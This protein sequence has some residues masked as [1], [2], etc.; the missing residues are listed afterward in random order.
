MAVMMEDCDKFSANYSLPTSIKDLRRLGGSLTM[1]ETRNYL[2]DRRNFYMA[3]I[4]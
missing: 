4:V 3:V 2:L 1:T